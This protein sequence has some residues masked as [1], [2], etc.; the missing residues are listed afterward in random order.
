MQKFE[1]T[2]YHEAGH[3][4]IAYRFNVYI[5]EVDVIPNS[6]R[7]GV[8]KCFFSD[9]N[10]EDNIVIL[11]A[12]HEAQIVFDPDDKSDPSIVDY[13]EIWDICDRVGIGNGAPYRELK[14]RAKQM[15]LDNWIEIQTVA[16]AL[17]RFERITGTLVKEIVEDLDRGKDYTAGWEWQWHQGT[18]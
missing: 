9:R 15:V 11:F 18:L 16:K 7:N 4:V 12:G 10:P 6:E 2:A 5:K 1:R 8:A 3:A 17:L 14:N 13:R